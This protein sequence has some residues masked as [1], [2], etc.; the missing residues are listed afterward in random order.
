[1]GSMGLGLVR[2]LSSEQ[3]CRVIV[4]KLKN[5]AIFVD[6]VVAKCQSHARSKKNG[7]EIRL[8]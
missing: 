2:A 7:R 8:D 6:H 5:S 1:M 4:G 3:Q